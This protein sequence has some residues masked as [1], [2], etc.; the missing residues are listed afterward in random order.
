MR[1][2]LIDELTEPA[3]VGRATGAARVAFVGGDVADGELEVRIA[4]GR[5]RFQDVVER[6]PFSGELGTSVL[7][8]SRG[9]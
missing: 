7:S 6:L 3:H 5:E 1:P 4:E 2:R 8:Q 9:P